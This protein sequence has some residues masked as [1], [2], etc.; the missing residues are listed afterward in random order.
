MKK[1]IPTSNK[2]ENR[3]WTNG[4]ELFTPLLPSPTLP[5]CFYS[6]CNYFIH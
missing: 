2:R 4:E 1:V 5:S 6:D 3:K